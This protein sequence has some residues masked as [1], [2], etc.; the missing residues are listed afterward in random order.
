[1]K[2]VL[3]F[4]S[5]IIVF[6]LSVNAQ[7]VSIAVNGGKLFGTLEIP[8]TEKKVDVVLIIAGSGPTDRDGNSYILKG[9][10]DMYKSFAEMLSSK[11]IASLRY[12]KRLVGKSVKTKEADLTF[13]AYINDAIEC[14]K[15]LKNDG[16]F[17]KIIIAGHSEGSLVGMVAAKLGNADKYISLCGA[18][19]SV[20]KIIL[21]QFGNGNLPEK[22]FTE[23][24]NCIDTLKHGNLL[25]YVN[26][27]L[28]NLLRAS[29]QPYLI[30]WLKY[31]PCKE[32]AKLKCPIL[33][34]AGTNDDQAPPN[35]TILLASANSNAEKLL[36]ENM[37]HA[38]KVAPLN[39]ELAISKTYIDPIIPLSEELCK[40][41]IEF[42][43]RYD[44]TVPQ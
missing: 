18:G 24:S 39:D 35:E 25:K 28:W 2:N 23:L 9:K 30:S 41:I 13:D 44:C 20:D 16:R 4:V 6:T 17:D 27:K 11:G 31:D 26:P 7:E 21:E 19:R 12:D 3:W 22:L 10:G 15:F 36:V 32:I 38:L 1:M 37:T 42:I 5:L 40:V 34:V 8:R 33:V 43:T 29:I 14:I